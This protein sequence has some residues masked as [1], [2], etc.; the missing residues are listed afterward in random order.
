MYGRIY[1]IL[2][3]L[4]GSLW[5][6]VGTF[7]L[8]APKDR[9]EEDER[10]MELCLRTFRLDPAWAAK[11]SQAAAQESIPKLVENER[12]PWSGQATCC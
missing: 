6:T 1:A 7:G 9:W 10:V 5:S 11:A 4:G 2:Y 8:I 3:D 12:L